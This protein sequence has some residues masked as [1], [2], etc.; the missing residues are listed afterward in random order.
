MRLE[1]GLSPH[2]KPFQKNLTKMAGL[3]EMSMGIDPGED[4]DEDSDDD[5]E[6]MMQGFAL[7]DSDN[8]IEMKDISGIGTGL[9]AFSKVE[10]Q[11]PNPKQHKTTSLPSKSFC[12]LNNQGAT[13]YMNSLL[14]TLFMTPEFRNALFRWKHD[15][16][17]D[18]AK[19]DCIPY[20]LQ[21]LFA[22]MA[23]GNHTS[24]G[25][26][27]LTRSFGW[28]DSQGFVQNGKTVAGRSS[29]TVPIHKSITPHAC[30]CQ[31]CDA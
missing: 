9:A 18:D 7:Q 24:I 5:L 27:P 8:S 1:G 23:L 21:T 16:V 20:Q 10:K 4:K 3:M 17:R 22:Q 28:D 12:G 30:H 25:T 26:K 13:C 11:V 15:P 29:T 14:Q 6:R 31:L 19:V 2:L